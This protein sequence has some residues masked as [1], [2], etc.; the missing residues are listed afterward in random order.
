VSSATSVRAS[1]SGN[2][3]LGWQFSYVGDLLEVDVPEEEDSL[4]QKILMAALAATGL[5]LAATTGALAAPVAPIGKAVNTIDARSS[6]Y[7]YRYGYYHH[8]RHCWWR[9]GRRICRW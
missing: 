8:H 1:R 5:A 4:M 3:N 2:Q 9:Y 6:V 7:Y